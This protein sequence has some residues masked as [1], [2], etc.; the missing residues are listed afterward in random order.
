MDQAQRERRAR[1]RRAQRFA[2]GLAVVFRP[3]GAAEWQTGTTA[4]L[5][6]SGALIRTHSPIMPPSLVEFVIVLPSSDTRMT[7]CLTGQ[8]RTIRTFTLL[9]ESP[10]SAFAIRFDEC[11]LERRA[12]VHA[13]LS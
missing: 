13:D 8:A 10:E 9:S 11:R 12:N 7:G 6:N 1:S 3:I 5:S 2:L 4:N